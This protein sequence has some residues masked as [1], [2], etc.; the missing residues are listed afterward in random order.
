MLKTETEVINT[1]SIIHGPS[2]NIPVEPIN[3]N[4]PC[5]SI[6]SF[7]SDN[8]RIYTRQQK[9]GTFRDSTLSQDSSICTKK[10]AR[11]DVDN[12][13]NFNSDC[14]NNSDRSPLSIDPKSSEGL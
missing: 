9:R 2:I 4:L 3:C 5:F 7:I 1:S 6:P 14:I 10:K 8:R 11:I 13:S 12:N